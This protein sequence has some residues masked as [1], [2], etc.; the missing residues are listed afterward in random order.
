M[1]VERQSPEQEMLGA[2]YIPKE[3]QM[4]SSSDRRPA[5]QPWTQRHVHVNATQLRILVVDDNINAGEALGAYLGTKEMDCRLAFGG[6]EAVRAATAWLPHVIVMDISMPECNGYQA[7]SALRH[8]ARTSATAIIA[9]TALDESE[10][11]RHLK[12]DEFDGYCQKGK[13]TDHLVA[14]ITQLAG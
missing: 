5:C 3:T 7:A 2:V 12:D 11:R 14:L 13:G 4:T 6:T 8:D 10:V 9:F 1:P